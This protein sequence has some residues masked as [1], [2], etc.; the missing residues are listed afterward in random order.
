[1]KILILK[2]KKY[3][4]FNKFKSTASKAY[5]KKIDNLVTIPF[6]NIVKYINLK[7][8]NYSYNDFLEDYSYE[9]EGKIEKHLI[10][11]IWKSGNS[12]NSFIIKNNI[13]TVL[14]R[15][16]RNGLD[17]NSTFKNQSLVIAIWEPQINLNKLKI[18]KFEGHVEL[19]GEKENLDIFKEKHNIKYEVLWDQTKD[20]Y[21]LAFGGILAEYIKKIRHK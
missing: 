20:S 10:W 5:I 8:I 2:L 21:H 19:H 9:L 3:G 18:T 6:Y 7:Q 17:S 1:M 16:L 15:Y 4:L 12:I 11:K 13:S 14:E